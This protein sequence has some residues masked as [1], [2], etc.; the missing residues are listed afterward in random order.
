MDILIALNNKEIKEQVKE[1]YN[2]RV[3]D[4]DMCLREDVID[5]LKAKNTPYI[6]VTKKELDGKIS[7]KDY[8][9]TIKN[10][11]IENR[12]I[13]LIE[14]L[15]DEEKRFL[16]SYEVFNI[17][18]GNEININYIYESI[19]TNNKVIYKSLPQIVKLSDKIKL[20][21]FGTNGSGKS[22]VS[23]IISKNIAKYTKLKVLLIDFD[24]ENSCIDIFNNLP[25]YEAMEEEKIGLFVDN[26]DYYKKY[27]FKNNEMDNLSY[28][29]IK[30]GKDNLKL[31]RNKYLNFL[32]FIGKDFDYLIIDLPSSTL[33]SSFKEVFNMVDKIIFVINPNYISLRQAKKYINIMI[34]KLNIKREL[35]KIVVNKD[36]LGGLDKKQIEGSFKYLSINCYIKY[37]KQMDEYINGT[38][39]NLNIT[40]KEKLQL[41]NSLGIDYINGKSLLEERGGKYEKQS[42]FIK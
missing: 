5:F 10:I 3:Y 2:G 6:I 37:L 29:G 35:F 42:Y 7:F 9:K 8:I 20:A 21:V 4:Y 38:I 32:N 19:E 25:N 34:D 12:V 41:L 33:N 18:E 40:K 23:Y 16:F 27:I 39:Y 36:T 11:N 1:K 28:V 17:I 15:E 14:K 13:I 22:F 31:N 24:I 26:E 30:K